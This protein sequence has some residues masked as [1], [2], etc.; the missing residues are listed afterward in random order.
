MNQEPDTDLV[1]SF[2]PYMQD[3]VR[4]QT[5]LHELHQTWRLIE[6]SAK[7]N[8][9]LE[10]RLL[11]PAVLA[12]RTGLVQLERD[13]VANMVSEKVRQVRREAATRAQY[14]LDLLVRNLFERTADVGFLAADL[15]L[16]RFLAR[17]AA[18]EAPDREAAR[19]RLVAYRDKYTVYD[20]I[21]LLAPDGAVLLRAD[22]GATLERSSDPLVEATLA[23]PGYVETCRASD[24]RPGA[25][26]AL[27]YSQ[28]MRD[29]DSGAILGVLCLSF[30]FEHELDAIFTAYGGAD[31]RA[32]MLLLDA[33]DRVVKSLDPLWIAPGVRVP[34]NLDDDL[35]ARLFAGREYLVATGISQG[36]QGY[37]G[38]PGWKTQVMVP[39]ELAFRSAHPDAAAQL[40]PRMLQGL[41]SHAHTF[42]PALHA[43]MSS[44][45]GATQ[46]IKR[47]VWNGKVTSSGA[48]AGNSG[49][50]LDPVLDQITETGERSDEAF[51]KSIQG[52]YQTVLASS[53]QEAGATAQLL[54]D[55]LDRSL[56]ERANDCRWWA[57]AG[58]LRQALADGDDPEQAEAI[59]VLLG[60][61][62]GLY[63]VYSRLFVYD[64]S[65]RI[66]AATGSQDVVGS[67]IA[68]DT[69]GA[70]CGLRSEMD[71]YA[72][73]FGA[74]ALYDGRPTFVYHAA[75]RHPE[76][77]AAVVGGIGIVFDSATELRNMLDSGVA[78]RADM[79]AFLVSPD[80]RVLCGTDPDQPAGTQLA[81]DRSLLEAAARHGAARRIV[82][83]AG[84]YCVAA[85]ARAGGYREFRAGASREEPVLSV[86][87]QSFGPV[88]E[89]AELA[90]LAGAERVRSEHEH[91]R[92]YALF[93]V[94]G[95]LMALDAGVVI[96]ALPFARVKRTPPTDG[97]RIGM[98][99]VEAELGQHPGQVRRPGFV[100]VFD[101]A[102][103]VSGRA[104]APR[105]DGQV[106]LVRHG[107]TTVGLLVDDVHSVQRF[108]PAE[109]TAIGLAGD[110]VAL[111]ASLIKANGGALLIQEL[112]A[113]RILERVCGAP[114]AA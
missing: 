68:S 29:P 38:P 27:L 63:T 36:Y 47:I 76:R 93:Q 100:W 110:D 14:A 57:L 97:A 25:P 102:R 87:L 15:D 79:Q 94:A 64:R 81:L 96:E 73:P 92:D 114:V 8:C 67:R 16:C 46:A 7:M 55:M 49:G 108:D 41:L 32:N 99:D 113:Q 80:G 43:L 5:A 103:L 19:R 105:A 23:A 24:L 107:A 75:I 59:G 70:V 88:R 101:L 51:S 78:G 31:R 65:G 84:Q 104:H 34:V 95:A 42:S 17:L 44:V 6:A 86:L 22:A 10:A 40:A 39:L 58:Q 20:D 109:S 60:H 3:V 37:P 66:V 26:H 18:G 52:L 28:A 85:C 13:L 112:S 9:P 33:D 4:R 106:I 48:A 83:H 72:E 2:L 35:A 91:G 12:T 62:N 56:Y 21:V 111:A 74:S 82:E 69:L 11:L 90:A 89:E 71:H 53:L 98:L 61:I 30:S 50:R 45:L 1:E 77:E 54:V